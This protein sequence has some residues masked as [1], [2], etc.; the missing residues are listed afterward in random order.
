MASTVLSDPV[1]ATPIMSRSRLCSRSTVKVTT[2]LIWKATISKLGKP[3]KRWSM[4]DFASPS[5]C[6]TSI[7]N[8]HSLRKVPATILDVK[9]KKF[10]RMPKSTNRLFFRTKVIPICK[11]R[12]FETFASFIILFSRYFWLN[13]I[14]YYTILRPTL[15]LDLPIDLGDSQALSHLD[16]QKSAMR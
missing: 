12:T 3:W 5:A 7:G 14:C 6:P 15:H 4:R 11:K 1:A 16:H 8:Q 2:A 9:S 10:T 13:L